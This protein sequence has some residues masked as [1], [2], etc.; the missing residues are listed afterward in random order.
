MGAVI[1]AGTAVALIHEKKRLLEEIGVIDEK[2][3]VLRARD[4]HITRGDEVSWEDIMSIETQG[5]PLRMALVVSPHLGF[6]VNSM[7]AAFIEIP[8]HST[9]GAYHRHGEAVKFYLSG[10][11]VEKIGDRVYDVKAGDTVF[12]PA[13]VW[14][15]TQNPTDDPV[16]IFAVSQALGATL[17]VPVIHART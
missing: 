11:A 8:P 1:E 2:L 3:G 9:E 12:I 7:R 15:G 13:N 16:R 10:H 6:N 17:D 4:C 5:A 14:H